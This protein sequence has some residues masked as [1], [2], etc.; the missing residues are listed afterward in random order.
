MKKLNLQEELELIEK[1]CYEYRFLDRGSSRAVF[2]IGDNKVMKVA[3]DEQGQTQN[4]NEIQW[5]EQLHKDIVAK[6]YSYGK[7]IVIMEEVGTPFNSEELEHI[8]DYIENYQ[9]FV[10]DELNEYYG[11]TEEEFIQIRSVDNYMSNA[12]GSTT[13]NHQIG[14]SKEGRWKIYDYGYDP[15][16]MNCDQVSRDLSDVVDYEG[17]EA[18]FNI[19]YEK[20]Q[21]LLDKS[22]KIEYNKL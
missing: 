16:M 1:Y 6:I 14:K 7:Y 8:I 21:N 2:S 15:R 5:Y 17:T 19:V 9:E 4:E 12:V 22:D 13:D 18:L 20:I 11:I 10:D 3:M